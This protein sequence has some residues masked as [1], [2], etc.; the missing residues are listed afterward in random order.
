[1]TSLVIVMGGKRRKSVENNCYS[2]GPRHA[3]KDNVDNLIVLS[4]AAVSMMREDVA[5]DHRQSSRPRRQG[6]WATELG[7]TRKITTV[8]RVGQWAVHHVS[9]R[10]VRTVRSCHRGGHA[11]KKKSFATDLFF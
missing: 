9:G 11:R 6:E 4:P 3:R 7:E 8:V 2:V 10:R 1:V 5:P